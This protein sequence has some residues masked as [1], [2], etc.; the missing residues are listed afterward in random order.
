M[1]LQTSKKSTLQIKKN[2]YK[3]VWDTTGNLGPDLEQRQT[4]DGQECVAI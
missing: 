4:F 1:I 3:T 2:I